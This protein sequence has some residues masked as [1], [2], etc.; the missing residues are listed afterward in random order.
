MTAYDVPDRRAPHWPRWFLRCSLTLAAV[1]LVAQSVTAGL[2][3]AELRAAFPVHRELATAAGV[4][5]MLGVIAAVLCVRLNGAAR[6]P[7]WATLGM[8]ALMSLAAFAGYRSLTALHVPIGV[9]TITSGLVL[10]AGSWWPRSAA[11]VGANSS[12]AL[13]VDVGERRTV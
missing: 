2:F 10:A 11:T 1:L 8:L 6:W 12:S 13:P 4:A 7:I 3:L 9:L 5:L